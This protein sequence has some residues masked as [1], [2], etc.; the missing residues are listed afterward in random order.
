M[1]LVILSFGVHTLDY[2]FPY[3][4]FLPFPFSFLKLDSSSGSQAGEFLP[5]REDLTMSGDM[6]VFL[7]KFFAMTR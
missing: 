7:K 5:I 2:S 1:K 3:I 6:C 4:V